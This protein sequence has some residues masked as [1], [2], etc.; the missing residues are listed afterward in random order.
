MTMPT[1]QKRPVLDYTTFIPSLPRR[2]EG[3]YGKLYAFGESD[4]GSIRCGNSKN[5]KRNTLLVQVLVPSQGH[6]H[7]PIAEPITD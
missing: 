1:L 2:F 5:I 7:V 4:A 6:E 3:F